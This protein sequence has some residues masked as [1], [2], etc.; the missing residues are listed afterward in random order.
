LKKAGVDVKAALARIRANIT[1]YGHHTTCVLG[2]EHPRHAHTIGLT[3]DIGAELL[4]GGAAWYSNEEVAA[5]VNEVAAALRAGRSAD[6]PVAT[7]NGVFTLRP[8]HASWACRLMPG[9][10]EYFGK[11]D[12]SALQVLP[13]QSY[14]TIDVPDMSRPYDPASAPLWRCLTEPWPF[15]I[16]AE[17]KAVTNLAALHGVAITDGLRRS[18]QVWELFAGVDPDVPE[19]ATLLVPI[20]TL[21]LHDAS[22]RAFIELPVGDGLKREPGGTWKPR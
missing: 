21:L 19:D 4:L 15:T 20:G 9:V 2:G 11:D 7:T 12:V 5:I 22:L 3:P 17:A 1:R 16:G 8:A 10:R 14:T 13:A 18:E 6:E